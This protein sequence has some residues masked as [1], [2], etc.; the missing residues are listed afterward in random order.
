M[1]TRLDD[2]LQAAFEAASES[3]EPTPGLAERARRATRARRRRQLATVAA[4]AAMLVA[5]GGAYAATARHHGSP[6]AHPASGRH[7]L[8]R[9]GYPVSQTAVSGRYLYLASNQGSLIAAYDRS[10]A[11]LV[12]LITVPGSPAWLSVGPGGLVWV[13]AIDYDGQAGAVLLL[14][15]DLSEHSTDASL[16]GAP[17][18]PT[19]RQTAVAPTQYGLLDVSM[20]APG[21][22]G[23]ASNRLV[24][25]SSLGPSQNTAPGAWAGLLA[26]MVVVQ[27]TNGY[28]YDSHLV[29]A[30]RPGRTFGGAL[31]HEVGE[32]TST[33]DALWVQ[34]FAIKNSYAASSGPLVRVDGQ[35]LATTPRFV[36]NSAVL[37]KTEDVWSSGDTIWAATAARGHALVCFSARSQAGPVI[38]VQASGT[39][40]SVAGTASTA[41][42]TTVEGD[43]TVTPAW[44][45]SVV[46]SLPV[47][48]GCR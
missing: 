36:E 32:V 11:K 3:I 20:P 24:P 22:Q 10:T 14:R 28:G 46:T 17:V 48:A 25:G 13:G 47:P 34:M 8:V 30:G 33:G 31:Q 26:G 6:P 15:P 38:T 40:A 18:V 12:R 44:G 23:R 7:V 42:V 29:S 27:V 4:C 9:V 43:S 41:Y 1:S 5:A 39:I 16:D 19:G 37:A 35:L 2:E 45:P 21:L